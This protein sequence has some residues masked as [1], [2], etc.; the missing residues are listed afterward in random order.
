[1]AVYKAMGLPLPMFRI[2]KGVFS[3]PELQAQYE[4]EL[5]KSGT[6]ARG[7]IEFFGEDGAKL[8]GVWAIIRGFGAANVTTPIH[9]GAHFYRRFMLNTENGFTAQ[10]IKAAED[11]AGA[12][13]GNWSVAAEEKWAWGFERYLRSGEAP[14]PR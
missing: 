8:D 9:E 3:K 6:L 10:E 14:C 1:M 11:W 2:A 5:E 13:N 4:A 12:R 7:F